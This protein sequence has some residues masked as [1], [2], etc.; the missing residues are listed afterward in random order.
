[1]LRHTRQ[2]N[3][4]QERAFR[5]GD[6]L[7]SQRA[8]NR[9]RCL[10]QLRSKLQ[11]QLPWMVLDQ[12]EP[13]P[14]PGHIAPQHAHPRN[15]HRHRRPIAIA[16]HIPYRNSAVLMQ[17]RPHHPHRSLNAV[18]PGPMRPRCASVRTT[19][20]V[21]CPHM[22]RYPVSL[23]KMTPATQLASLASSSSAPTTT[24]EPRGSHT[25]LKRK[26]SCRSRNLPSLSA[27]EPAPSSGPPAT[28]TRVGSPA[29]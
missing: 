14:T 7:L 1:M 13:V 26:S 22:P 17:H 5:P 29:V 27:S 15:I 6:P 2:L 11:L 4:I 21:P 18:L 16:R 10:G 23:K 3:M 20:I 19:P 28:T 9:P 24:S 8:P 12:K 25:T